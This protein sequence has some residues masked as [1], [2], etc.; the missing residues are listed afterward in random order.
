MNVLTEVQQDRLKAAIQDG[1]PLTATPYRTLSLQLD[2][3]EPLV[4][5]QIEHWLR[6]GYI[7]RMGLVVRHH[8][9]GYRSNAMVVWNVADDKVDQVGELLRQADCV[10]LCYKRR[11]Q[12]PDWPYNLYCMIHG[13]SRESVLTQLE[14]L[15]RQYEL[16]HIPRSILFSNQQFKQT[17]GHYARRAS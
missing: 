11:R 5:E 9:V 13:K 10:T 7:K 14:L 12:L 15:T 2:L 6:E 8:A 1:L 3:P 4:M 17:G 16:Q